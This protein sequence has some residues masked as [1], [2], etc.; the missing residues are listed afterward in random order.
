MLAG[1]W[2]NQIGIERNQQKWR[3]VL[4]PLALYNIEN[5]HD[6]FVKRFWRIMRQRKLPDE[7]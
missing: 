4:R 7:P 2:R 3:P 6:L 1:G 5:T